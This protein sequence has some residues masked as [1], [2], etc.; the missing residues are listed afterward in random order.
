MTSAKLAPAA[1][2]ELLEAQ[3]F[4]AAITPTLGER[5]TETITSALRRIVASPTASPRVSA[6][7]RRYVVS[8]FPYAILYRIEN[9]DVL[10]TAIAHQRRRFGYWR[11]R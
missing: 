10:V 1:R 8:V 4:Y 5:F 3:A 2:R 11:G 6:R 7:M 9:G